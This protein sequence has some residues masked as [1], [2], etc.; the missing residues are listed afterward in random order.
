MINLI[1]IYYP[2]INLCYLKILFK[3][4]IVIYLFHLLS[5][6]PLPDS[7]FQAENGVL[8]IF[9]LPTRPGPS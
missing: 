5:Y 8:F 3:P 4:Y 6:P 7:L 2:V 1:A 9:V